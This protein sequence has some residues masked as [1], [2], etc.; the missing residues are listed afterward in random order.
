M[1]MFLV[2]YIGDAETAAFY[3]HHQFTTVSIRPPAEL[4]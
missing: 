1:V 2:L 3:Y 4:E